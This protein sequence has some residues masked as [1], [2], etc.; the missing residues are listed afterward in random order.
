MIVITNWVSIAMQQSK[1][2]YRDPQMARYYADASAPYQFD[3]PA[4]DLVKFL[5][6]SPG[7]KILDIGSGTGLI[8]AAASDL[9]TISGYVLAL[10]GSL[11]MLKRQPENR[12]IHIVASAQDLPFDDEIFDRTTAGFVITH[13]SDYSKGLSE[14]TRVLRSGGILAASAWEVGATTVS[15]IWKST[16]KQFVELT[17]VEEAFARVIPWDEFFSVR[18]NLTKT[19]EKAGLINVKSE[20]KSYLFVM[21]FRQYIDSKMGSVEGTIVRNHLD[22]KTWKQFLEKLA[23]NLQNEFPQRI[24]Y[25]RN[26]HF[27]SGQKGT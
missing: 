5:Q 13:L 18:A 14:W 11:E 19:F 8:A 10:D 2:P 22:E 26:V 17:I 7:H 4:R 12:V 15:D 20:T 24:E 16:V 23:H 1:S 3:Q 21:D 9:C 27:A 25:R 6:I